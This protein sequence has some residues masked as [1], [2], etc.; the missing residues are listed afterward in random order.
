MIEIEAKKTGAVLVQG[1]GIAGVQASLDLANSGFKVYLVEKEPSIGGMMARLDKTFPTGDCAT[2][3][4]SPKYVE[5]AR[6][7][8]IEIL[9]LSELVGLTGEPGN[10]KASIQR[11][12]RHVDEEKCNGCGECIQNCPVKYE[13]FPESEEKPRIHLEEEA[14]VQVNDIIGRYRGVKG[15]LMP[16]LKEINTRFNYLP[17]N[18]LR[19][20]SIELNIP[21]SL[22]YRIATFYNAFSLI[23]RGRHIVN[24]CSGTTCYVRGSEKF[25]N[26]LKDNLEF[27]DGSTTKDMRFTLETVRCL[28][29][30]SMA[31]VISVDGEIYGN[32]KR[33]EIMEVLEQYE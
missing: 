12:A 17:E 33:K 16:V 9:T 8:N 11:T 3:I 13:I 5:C 10:F 32:L 27:E 6:N 24:V 26:W 29:C 18:I 7:R 20:V 15:N 25:L 23:P 4:G 22:I 14:F 19:Y 21:L 30:C 2:C 31:P 1:G 28:G